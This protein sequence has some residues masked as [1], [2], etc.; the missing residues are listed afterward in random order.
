VTHFFWTTSQDQVVYYVTVLDQLGRE[1]RGWVRCG[2]W[3]LG[4][5]S[6]QAD[7]RRED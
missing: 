3:F 4:M 7:V 2:S 1:R 6:N 5:F